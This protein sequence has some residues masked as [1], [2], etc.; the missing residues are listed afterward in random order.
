[1]NGAALHAAMRNSH[2]EKIY[3]EVKSWMCKDE[4][5][6]VAVTTERK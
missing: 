6:L 5:D 2:Y 1:M 4:S 3:H